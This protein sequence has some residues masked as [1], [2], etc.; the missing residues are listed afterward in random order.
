MALAHLAP[1]DDFV[2][3]IA[4]NIK[5]V[6]AMRRMKQMDLADSIGMIESTLSSRING[7]SRWLG[8][9]LYAIARALEVDADVIFADDEM[10]LREALSRSRCSDAN[11]LLTAVETFRGQLDMLD[12]DGLPRVFDS[13]ASLAALP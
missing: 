1:A 10:A 2:Q 6:L 5:T 3:I 11:T 7:G 4:R 13:V 9:E 12:E 8:S